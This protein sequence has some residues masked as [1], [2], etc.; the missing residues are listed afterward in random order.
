MAKTPAYEKDLLDACDAMESIL[1]QLDSLKLNAKIDIGAR[2]KAVMKNAE[3]ID[4]K[5]KDEIKTHLAE[6]PGVV[7]GEVFKAELKLIDK[8][9]FD[10]KTF[11]DERPKL[12]EEYKD[13]RTE[14][15]VLYD[16]R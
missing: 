4:T 5:I 12:F 8:E 6:K 2:V 13:S 7:L 10:Q 14:K 11:K 16:V 3:K 15:H 9:F 1:A